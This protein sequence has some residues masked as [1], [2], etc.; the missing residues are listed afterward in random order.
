MNQKFTLVKIIA[1]IV[2][3][4]LFNS[5]SSLAENDRDYVPPADTPRRT[6]ASRT[7]GSRGCLQPINADLKLLVPKDHVSITISGRPTFFWYISEKVPVPV[8]FSLAESQ[9]GIPVIEQQVQIEKPGI[10]SFKLP[11]N[12]PE[13]VEGKEYQWTVTIV[14]NQWRPSE[15]FYAQASLI[16]V[17][18]SE[19]LN[20]KIKT[21]QT[22]TEKSLIY[23][24]SGIWYDA[25]ANLY[26][27]QKFAEF[28]QLLEQVGLL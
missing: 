26:Q 6:K 13:L 12:V 4:Y 5:V 16:R 14:C 23:A 25:L 9:A 2:F 18:I 11:D 17:P 7:G 8:L 27:Q 22:D 1:T 20:Q 19:E 24:N 28:W 21:V 15:N 10:I 3:Y